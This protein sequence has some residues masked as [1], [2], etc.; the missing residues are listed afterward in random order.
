[1]PTYLRM[2]GACGG[3]RNAFEV[4]GTLCCLEEPC[5]HRQVGPVTLMS[6]QREEAATTG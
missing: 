4:F 2:K 3:R 6:P 1:M 5:Y